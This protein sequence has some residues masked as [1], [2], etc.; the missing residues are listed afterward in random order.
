MDNF[1]LQVLRV[2]LTNVTSRALSSIVAD[3]VM[4]AWGLR[5]YVGGSIRGSFLVVGQRGWWQITLDVKGPEEERMYAV[6]AATLALSRREPVLYL[7]APESDLMFS[8][9]L[10]AI[11]SSP[12]PSNNV[13]LAGVVSQQ[14][15]YPKRITCNQSHGAQP[16][17]KSSFT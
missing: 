3:P 4:G 5:A 15:K 14:T 16:V 17:T 6:G 2:E 10:S 12:Q 13:S 9:D 1:T 11:R 7:T 8:L